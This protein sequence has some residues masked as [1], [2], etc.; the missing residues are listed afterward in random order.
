MIKTMFHVFFYHLL[1]N[2]LKKSF[3]HIV[4][5]SFISNN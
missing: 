3:Y 1:F 4:N 5:Y 2:L